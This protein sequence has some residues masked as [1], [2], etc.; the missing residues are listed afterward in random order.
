MS[1]AVIAIDGPAASGKSSVSRGLAGQLGFD[2]INSGVMYRA[3]AWRVL[4]LGIQPSD[5]ARVA[6]FA[7]AIRFESTIEDGHAV[8]SVDGFRPMHELNEPQVNKAVSMVSAVPAVRDRVVESIRGLAQ[9]RPVVVEGR[10][11]GSVVF[12]DTP[13]KFYLDAAPEIR[14]RRRASQGQEDVIAAR[15]RQDSS[16]HTAPLRI[17]NDA[18]VIDT[19]ALDLQGVIAAVL[20][21]LKEQGLGAAQ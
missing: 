6:E 3:I 20:A 10:D 12:P 7:A 14:E 5:E 15:D 2:Y 1:G 4:G 18:R 13:Y 19:S 17:A 11:I 21:A 16:R 9:N 8:I